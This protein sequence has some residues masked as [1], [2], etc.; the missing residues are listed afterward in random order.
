MEM[1]GD[2][3]QYF[4][5]WCEKNITVYHLLIQKI[6][7]QK[8]LLNIGDDQES[9]NVKRKISFNVNYKY[10]KFIYYLNPQVL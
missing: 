5:F 6:S 4:L 2:T 7:I 10:T 9:E 1:A 8:L 3:F